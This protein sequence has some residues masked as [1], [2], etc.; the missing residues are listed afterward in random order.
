[1]CLRIFFR[2]HYNCIIRDSIAVEN[3][4]GTIFVSLDSGVVEALK[5]PAVACVLEG[6]RLASL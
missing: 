1:M 6:C 5:G 2:P 4:L 3:S